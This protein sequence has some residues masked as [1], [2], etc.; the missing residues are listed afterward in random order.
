MSSPVRFLSKNSKSCLMME[1]KSRVRRRVTI[2]SPAYFMR[3]TR[4][5]LAVAPIAKTPIR[6][7]KSFGSGRMREL[8]EED[9]DDDP[10]NDGRK[11]PKL[12]DDG[13]DSVLSEDS[14]FSLLD[15]SSFNDEITRSIILPIL[16]GTDIVTPELMKSKKM[17]AKMQS[18]SIHWNLIA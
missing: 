12:V 1:L 5:A 9:V 2:R 14:T 10:V 11:F 7:P 17:A 6:I 16:N 4:P 3:M 13:V 15:D 8:V 18:I